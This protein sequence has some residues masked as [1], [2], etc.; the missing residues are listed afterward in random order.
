MA[1][2]P[3]ANSHDDSPRTPAFRCNA[4]A[5]QVE[6]EVH[7]SQPEERDVSQPVE[8]ALHTRVA[9]KPVLALEPQTEHKPD[10]KP[11]RIQTQASARFS[12]GSAVATN[13]SP[14]FTD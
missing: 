13:S 11:S 6:H 9:A 12:T 14:V 10:P 2:A 7:R 5:V 1:I 8:P 4:C 3:A